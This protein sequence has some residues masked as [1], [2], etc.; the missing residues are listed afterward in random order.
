MRVARNETIIEND[1]TERILLAKRDKEERIDAL[2]KELMLLSGMYRKHFDQNHDATRPSYATLNIQAG[3]RDVLHGIHISDRPVSK[4]QVEDSEVDFRYLCQ[5]LRHMCSLSCG[6]SNLAKYNDKDAKKYVDLA[7]FLLLQLVQLDQDRRELIA[8]AV[9]S[10]VPEHS[11]RSRNGT[12]EP[13][14]EDESLRTVTGWF[15]KLVEG[16]VPSLATAPSESSKPADA[17]NDNRAS[18]VAP[19]LTS[20][21]DPGVQSMKRLC[22]LV[23]KNIASSVQLSSDAQEVSLPNR[24]KPKVDVMP[25]VDTMKI[26]DEQRLAFEKCARR[27]LDIVDQM[28]AS[29][30]PDAEAVRYIMEMLC[31]SGTL[32]AARLCNAVHQRFSNADC[33]LQFALVLDSYLEAIRREKDQDKVTI[34]VCEAI[35]LMNSQWNAS[36]PSHRVERILHCSIVLNCMAVG[37]MGR[38]SGMCERGDVMVM[39]TLGSHMSQS[40]RQELDADNP[41][42]DSQTLPLANYLSH[43]YAT[44]DDEGR[45]Y[46]AKKVLKYMMHSHNGIAFPNTDTCN[47]VLTALIRLNESKSVKERVD[48]ASQDFEFAKDVLRFMMETGCDPNESTL[49]VLFRFLEVT[50]PSDIGAVAE[51]FLVTVETQQL[52]SQSSDVKIR[53]ATYHRVMKYWLQSAQSSSSRS[54]GLACERA[55]RLLRRLEVQSIP[56]SLSDTALDSIEVKSLYDI[57]LRPLRK[58]YKMVMQICAETSDSEDHEK[59]AAIALKVQ[60]MMLKRRFPLGEDSDGLMDACLSRLAPDSTARREIEEFRRDLHARMDAQIL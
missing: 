35:D 28:P 7:E 39:R 26:S 36:W 8:T 3:L 57:G 43:L 42:V 53:L 34:V 17:T 37:N 5:A 23:L 29:W 19:S 32:P 51:D 27:M 4:K 13:H 55:F 2:F 58:T 30:P 56:C 15:S 21:D 1:E 33:K 9:D 31:R 46:A 45:I 6:L 47:A 25:P 10:I 12:R 52:L 60:R 18:K 20:E 38:L 54:G 41:K 49:N 48:A 22:R 59:A 14:F 24:M 16:F 11:Q 40:F 50:N 44:S